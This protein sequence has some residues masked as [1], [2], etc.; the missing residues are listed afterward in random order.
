MTKV[1]ICGV[2]D[3]E[4]ARLAAELGAW[5]IGMILWPGSERA[6][7]PDQ[8][9]VI[10]AELRR[11]TE[12]AGVF[13][14]ATLDEVALAA[15]RFGLTLLQLHG[16]EGPAYCREAARRTGCRVMKAARVKD[17]A[18]IRRLEPFRTDLHLLDAHARGAYGGTGTT[19]DWELVRGHPAD[20]P[21]V[22]SG[23]L[24]PENVGAAIAAVRPFA[25]DTA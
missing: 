2:T 5:A 6:C 13:V 3:I 9:D 24:T 12:L 4:D 11:E 17:A 8:A 22:L 19:F 25:V 21:I 23:G 20:L 16:D 7:P 10:G 14:N 18:S 15:D 1:K